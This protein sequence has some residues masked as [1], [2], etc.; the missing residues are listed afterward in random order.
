[1]R[2][3]EE[4]EALLLAAR[5]ARELIAKELPHYE[6]TL[7]RLDRA[8][9]GV[10]PAPKKKRVSSPCCGRCDHSM[11]YHLTDHRWGPCTFIP[12]DCQD[13]LVTART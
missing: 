13:F 7:D 5:E 12:C 11:T 10:S 9:A 3:P 4:I 6:G 1:M 8:I 2:L